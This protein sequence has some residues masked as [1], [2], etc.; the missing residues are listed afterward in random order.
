MARFG[1]RSRLYLDVASMNELKDVDLRR[2][3]AAGRYVK[4][5]TVTV[6]FA[7]SAG[8][9]MSL[10]GPNRY[11]SGD[12]LVTGTGGARWVVERAR[13]DDKYVPATPNLAHGEAGNYRNRPVAVLAKR[14]TQPFSIARTIDGDTLTGA[15]GDWL[16][17]YAPGDYGVVKAQRFAAVYRSLD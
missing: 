7:G 6:E 4:D 9:L 13:F 3:A 2:D 12:A 15:A 1:L 10:E 14:M 8:T 5:E 11:E 17:Q 16:M